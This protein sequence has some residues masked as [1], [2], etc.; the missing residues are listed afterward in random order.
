[1]HAF[2]LADAKNKLLQA[3]IVSTLCDD[4]E[5]HAALTAGA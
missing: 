2:V 4:H 1:M 3:T 5:H